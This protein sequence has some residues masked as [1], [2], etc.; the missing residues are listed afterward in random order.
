MGGSFRNPYNIFL[1]GIGPMINASLFAAMFT[2]FG[3]KGAWGSR[4][5]TLVASW[6]NTGMEVRPIVHMQRVPKCQCQSSTAA[7]CST[8]EMMAV[9]DMERNS[10]Q[11]L[12]SPRHCCCIATILSTP[13]SPPAHT[14]CCIA[15][16][17]K[18]CLLAI[19]GHISASRRHNCPASHSDCDPKFHCEKF[20]QIN[21]LAVHLLL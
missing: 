12:P 14:V 5:K 11:H 1:L 15:L 7:R 8:R 4:A 21:S 6:K 17:M 3:E 20:S 19:T 9:L 13:T 16:H 18:A 2:G 10:S